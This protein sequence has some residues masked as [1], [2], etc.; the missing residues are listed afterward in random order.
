MQ[1]TINHLFLSTVSS[2]F[3]SLKLFLDEFSVAKSDTSF[4]NQSNLT[5]SMMPFLISR[6]ELIRLGTWEINLHHYL[7]ATMY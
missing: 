6:A 3:T 5:S 1:P 4:S 2:I 7:L